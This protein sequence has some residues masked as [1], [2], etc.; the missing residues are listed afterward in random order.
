MSQV[1]RRT[2]QPRILF[3]GNQTSSF[4]SNDYKI[5]TKHYPVTSHS[6]TQEGHP[7]RHLPRFILDVFFSLNKSDIVFCWFANTESFLPI[8]FGKI[9]KKKTVVVAGGYDCAN[10]PSINYG[11]FA[12]PLKRLIAAFIFNHVNIVLAVSDFTKH[13]A[14]SCTHPHEIKTVYNGVDVDKF[15]PG[16]DRK[17]DMILTVASV[18]KLNV[19]LKGLRTFAEASKDLV[20][21]KIVIIGPTDEKWKQELMRINPTIQFIGQL[22]HDDLVP[23]FRRTKIYCQLS[24]R[25][26]FGLSLVEA[27]S[28]GCIPVTTNHGA[29]PEVVGDCGL[30]VPFKDVNATATALTS[31]AQKTMENQACARQRAVSHFS[32]KTREENLIQVIRDL[33]R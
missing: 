9:L 16:T 31:A 3:V 32:L 1:D 33:S 24:Y 4:V 14:L 7:A 17:E 12:H 20:N 30:I 27:M 18:D 5:L 29:L 13:E 25:E 10:E 19:D 6:F 15:S 21:F 22:P 26:S 2:L 23:W 28:C 11:N 8:F